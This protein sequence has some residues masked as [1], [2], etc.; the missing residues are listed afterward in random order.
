MQA[1]ENHNVYSRIDAWFRAANEF[2]SAVDP[3]TKKKLTDKEVMEY[4]LEC[5]DFF[6][7]KIMEK[8]PPEVRIG[9]EMFLDPMGA[10]VNEENLKRCREA[11]MRQ[12][13]MKLSVGQRC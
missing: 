6:V 3:K 10:T 11:V 12:L 7:N 13:K 2:K 5:K 8:S 4:K 1:K 9:K